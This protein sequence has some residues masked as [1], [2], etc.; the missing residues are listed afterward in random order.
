MVTAEERI[1]ATNIGVGSQAITSNTQGKEYVHELNEERRDGTAE[2]LAHSLGCHGT[3]SGHVFQW[4]GND[5]GD[6]GRTRGSI[7]L[8]AAID[9]REEAAGN[10]GDDNTCLPAGGK[11]NDERSSEEISG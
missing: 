1:G 7:H 4:S 8:V 9:P 10:Q 6:T 3:C 5:Y 11:M 2:H